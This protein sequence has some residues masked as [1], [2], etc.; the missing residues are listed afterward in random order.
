M[1][2]VVKNVW[3]QRRPKISNRSPK[4]LRRDPPLVAVPY[5]ASWWCLGN[6]PSIQCLGARW[7]W[8]ITMAEQIF[9]GDSWNQSTQL[10]LDN[11]S[12]LFSHVSMG[13]L[14]REPP[15]CAMLTSKGLLCTTR[16]ELPGPTRKVLEVT[17][18]PTKRWW[19]LALRD[20]IHPTRHETSGRRMT[21]LGGASNIQGGVEWQCTCVGRPASWHDYVLAGK[22]MSGLHVYDL[23]WK[24]LE[25]LD[26][27]RPLGSA[28]PPAS[29]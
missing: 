27:R 13:V 9:S 17:W 20:A 10:V 15:F 2:I 5:L 25:H 28:V 3:R 6:Y 24:V 22:N 7:S 16:F 1:I 21:S 18:R 4:W 19:A 14:F 29:W 26:S 8:F 23:F 11:L 12:L